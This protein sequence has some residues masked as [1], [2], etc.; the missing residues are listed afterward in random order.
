VPDWG[1]DIADHYQY[2]NGG[3][4]WAVLFPSLAI[5]TLVIGIN[6]IADAIAQTFER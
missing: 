6:L 2:I 5:A 3:V 4:W 1:K